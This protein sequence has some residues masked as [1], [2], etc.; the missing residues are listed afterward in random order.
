GFNEHKG[1]GGF[2]DGQK[3]R[4]GLLYAIIEDVEVFALEILDKFAGGIGHEYTDVDAV[5][6]NADRLRLLRFG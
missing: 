3:I 5:D 1:L 4:D 2:F 6:A